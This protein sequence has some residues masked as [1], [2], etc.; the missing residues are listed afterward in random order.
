VLPSYAPD[1]DKHRKLLGLPSKIIVESDDAFEGVCSLRDFE[2]V[3]QEED[4]PTEKIENSLPFMKLWV[5]F[6]KILP[7]AL[8]SLKPR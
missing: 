4:L 8:N 3:G 6:G 2:V 5:I 7:L 1:S